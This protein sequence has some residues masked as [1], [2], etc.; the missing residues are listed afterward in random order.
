MRVGANCH[1]LL[2][3]IIRLRLLREPDAEIVVDPDI[4]ERVSA[5][6][7]DTMRPTAR[8]NFNVNGIKV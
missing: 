1:L 3:L 7:N 5:L 2:K 4:S 6:L 8:P